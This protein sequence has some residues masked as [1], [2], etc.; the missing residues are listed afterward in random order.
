MLTLTTGGGMTEN[1]TGAALGEQEIVQ[2][3]QLY[4][5]TLVRV[6]QIFISRMAKPPEVTI[7]ENEEG[8]IV[9]QEEEDTDEIALY[10][11]MREVLIYLT[12]LGPESMERIMMERLSSEVVSTTVA[13]VLWGA[14]MLAKWTFPVALGLAVVEHHEAK[15]ARSV[16]DAVLASGLRA[17]V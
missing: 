1:I 5:E 2:K 3:K 9:R 16:A 6:R 4:E 12:N 14:I 7:K 17:T 11:Y 10:K 8:H 15:L 13:S